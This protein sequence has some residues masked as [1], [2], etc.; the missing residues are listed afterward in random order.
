MNRATVILIHA[1]FLMGLLFVTAPAQDPGDSAAQGLS[2]RLAT[3]QTIKMNTDLNLSTDQFQEVSQINRTEIQNFLPLL[4]QYKASGDKQ[5]FIKG[6]LAISKTRDIRLQQVLSPSQWKVYQ[7]N[8]SERTA[9]LMTQ[10]MAF[11]LNLTDPQISQVEQINLT[12]AHDMQSE[13]GASGNV[14]SGTLR[15]KLRVVRDVRSAQEE[16]DQ[17][18]RSVLTPEQWSAYQAHREEMKGILK[19]KLQEQKR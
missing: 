12:A 11:Q 6:A 16:R 19:E 2:Q 7:A 14:Q 13:M 3:R 5:G 4:S 9:E 1:I 15:D 10:M 18:L 17:S 8:K